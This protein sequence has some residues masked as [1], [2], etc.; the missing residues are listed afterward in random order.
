VRQL[1]FFDNS[2][3]VPV[4]VADLFGLDDFA[5]LIVNRRSQRARVSALGAALGWGEPLTVD[6]APL[7]RTALQRLERVAR[8]DGCVLYV[9]SCVSFRAEDREL[10]DFLE[11]LSLSTRSVQVEKATTPPSVSSEGGAVL[12][13]RGP[14]LR[15]LVEAAS[16]G[17]TA[18]EVASLGAQL[19]IVPAD[20]VIDD[21]RDPVQLLAAITSTFDS[22]HFNSVTVED[23]FTIVKRSTDVAKARREYAYFGLLPASMRRFFV[24]PFDLRV[25]ERGASYRMER[26]LVPDVALQ[27][28]HHAFQ[29]AQFEQ[30]LDALFYFLGARQKR[31]VEPRE[32]RRVADAL[33]VEKVKERVAALVAMEAFQ[34]IAPQC[35]IAFGGVEALLARYLDLYAAL[36][37]RRDDATLVVGHG[38]LCFSNILYNRA[39]ATL[40]LVDPRG[41]SDADELFVDPW[42]DLAK[43]SH[44]IEGGYDLINA[45]FFTIELDGAGI[46]QLRI[47]GPSHAA[48]VAAFRRRCRQAGFDPRLVRLYEAS[49]FISMA[50]LHIDAPRKVM[51]FLMNAVR[52][53]DE[54][55]SREGWKDAR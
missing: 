5:E 17:G 13:L 4:N 37:A 26:L 52:I 33:Y 19:P 25:D 46:P 10:A 24:E 30:L 35:R 32:A 9:P 1:I 16:G 6:R 42:Y 54:V 21:L 48:E 45:G 12:A 40:K 50:P 11:K 3:D 28:L 23:R 55:E 27:W 44:S 20:V 41:A 36:G 29:P 47:H 22:R 18:A 53:L 39:F 14:D 15:R 7:R 43:L 38:D 31:A 2:Y 34:G 51:A 8:N 49:L